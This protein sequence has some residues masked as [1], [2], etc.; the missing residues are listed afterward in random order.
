MTSRTH[1]RKMIVI[2]MTITLFVLVVGMACEDGGTV[3]NTADSV[4]T[5]AGQVQD[6]LN[7]LDAVNDEVFPDNANSVSMCWVTYA[8]G[9]TV[10]EVCP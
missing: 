2:V 10:R 9:R 5:G 8:D 7:A 3:I 4:T 6:A 1:A